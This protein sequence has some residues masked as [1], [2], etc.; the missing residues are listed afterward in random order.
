[1]K[2]ESDWDQDSETDRGVG[3]SGLNTPRTRS[4]SES[5]SGSG[6]GSDDEIQYMGMADVKF[7]S[8]CNELG[9]VA[10]HCA[11]VSDRVSATPSQS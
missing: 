7:C 8:I 9:H 3:T 2:A 4:G 6:S 11:M 10:T 5:A 1:M